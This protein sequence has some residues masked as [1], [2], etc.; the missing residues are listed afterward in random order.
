MELKKILI[1][2]DNLKAKGNLDIDIKNIECDSRK[3]TKDTL[4]VAIT[5]YDVD[6][7]D[8]IDDAI[9]NGATKINNVTFDVENDQNMCNNMLPEAI[10]NTRTRAGIIAK[11]LNVQI[12][13][14]SK[15]SSSCY[16]QNSSNVITYANARKATSVDMSSG[17]NYETASSNTS[18]EPKPIKVRAS[19]NVDYKI[20]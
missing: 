6:G 3:V 16:V 17:N 19:V 11:S 20:K 8:F 14:V 1:G 15:V 9:N 12:S 2:L 7:H 5:G 4:F 13:G 10:N 18:I